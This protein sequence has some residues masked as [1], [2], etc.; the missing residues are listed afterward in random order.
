MD[1]SSSCAASVL[2]HCHIGG[3]MA[4]NDGV[5]EHED[6][7]GQPEEQADDGQEEALSPG[8]VHVGVAGGVDGIVFVVGNG[9]HR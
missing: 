3:Q 6:K 2:G 5:Q 9:Q 7:Q 4:G 1:V 8:R